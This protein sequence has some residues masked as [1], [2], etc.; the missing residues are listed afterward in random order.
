MGEHGGMQKA[1]QGIAECISQIECATTKPLLVGALSFLNVRA[2][3][4]FAAHRYA[5]VGP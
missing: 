2:R 4:L 5:A 1:K 3:I